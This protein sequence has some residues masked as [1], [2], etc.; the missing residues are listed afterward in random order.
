MVA[1]TLPPVKPCHGACYNRAV[2]P[3]QQ[4]LEQ[5]NG[6]SARLS[7]HYAKH[8]VC[9]AGCS[10][11][12]HHHL[13]VFQVE[14]DFVAAAITALP[15]AVQQ[16]VVEQAREV[17][18]KETDD[19]PVV[20]PMLVAERCAIYDARPVICRTQGLPL[21]LEA[22]DGTPAVDFCPLN[23]T[24]PQALADLT[25]D[26]LVQLEAINLQLAV[27]NLQHC[28]AQGL[29]D[30]QSGT[31]VTMSEVILRTLLP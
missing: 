10:S 27:L 2:T 8:L 4:F 31:R 15:V 9:R 25:E 18:E 23:F 6:L 20:C 28:R 5:I 17:L 16:Q 19:L 12:C 21:L 22:E 14:A 24:A 11:C 30:E 26:K 29:T 3:Y 13:S 7:A 1:T